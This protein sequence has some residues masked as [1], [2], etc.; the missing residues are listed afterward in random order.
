MICLLQVFLSGCGPTKAAI[1]QAYAKAEEAYGKAQ[2][3]DEKIKI[4]KDFLA[5][6]PDSDHTPDILDTLYYYMVDEGGDA[7]GFLTYMKILE[8]R[9]HASTSK[10]MIQVLK[11]SSLGRLE[12]CGDIETL[13]GKL[14]KD[15]GL[16]Y[17]ELIRVAHACQSCDQWNYVLSNVEAAL[18]FAT[19]EAF[20]KDYPDYDF[21]PE[22]LERYA[23][24]RKAE[25]LALKGWA[26]FHLNKFND[27]LNT[28][29]KAGEV[30]TFSLVGVGENPLNV[31]RGRTLLAMGRV[32][33][34][35]ESVIPDAVFAGDKAALDVLR[36]IYEREPAPADTFDQYVENLREER[37]PLASD[38][39][40]SGYDGA[41]R[42]FQE[43]RGKKATLLTFWF[44]T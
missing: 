24:R 16:S 30:E 12:R 7:E 22:R 40:L 8:P 44:P 3:S 29:Q 32:E 17:D 28:F 27:A 2:K 39:S 33:E 42:D 14:A 31:Y 18:N 34:A 13:A 36:E 6:Y 11:I 37:A 23:G 41:S 26:Q 1:D 38:F 4:F 19:P 20:Q 25:S 35:R 5:L 43:L 15:A 21:T 10:T 9:V